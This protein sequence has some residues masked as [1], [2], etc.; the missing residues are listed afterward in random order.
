[1]NDVVVAVGTIDAYKAAWPVFCHS[2]DRYWPDCPWPVVFMTNNR[3]GPCGRTVKTGGDHAR[4]S[5][6]TRRGLEQIKARVVLW[7]TEDNWLTATVDTAALMDFAGHVLAGDLHHARL[8]PG[9]DHDVD[10]GPFPEDSRLL[11]FAR[12]SPYRCSLKPSLWRRKIFFRL[13]RDGEAPWAFE[14]DASRRSRK[15]GDRFAAVRGWN[16]FHFV[17]RG[18]PSSSWAEKSPLVKGKW[19]TAAREYCEREGLEVDLTKHPVLGD[20]F[21]GKPPPYILP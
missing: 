2:L 4:W 1:M 10:E 21:D 19:T 17:T 13:L 15:F 16:H 12:E 8:Y 7:M 6:R 20:P 9:W 3:E 14:R 5:E 18:C 11:V